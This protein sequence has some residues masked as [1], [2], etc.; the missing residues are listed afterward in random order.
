MGEIYSLSVRGPYFKWIQDLSSFG[1]RFIITAGN[2]GRLYVTM[3][4]T[5]I[6]LA[7]DVST[8]SILWQGS[9]GPLSSADYEPVVDSNGEIIIF[10]FL[11]FLCFLLQ[12]RI[13]ERIIV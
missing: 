13:I 2:N 9:I 6:V 11:L 8:G 12:N 4:D 5:D 3:P 7:L 10:F 1:S